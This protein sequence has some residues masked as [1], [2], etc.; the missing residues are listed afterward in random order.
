MLKRSHPSA[1]SV[2]MDAAIQTAWLKAGLKLGLGLLLLGAVVGIRI[3]TVSPE[4]VATD[5][6]TLDP[7]TDR[8][9]VQARTTS[10]AAEPAVPDSDDSLIGDLASGVIEHLPGAGASRRAGDEM[11]SCRSRG[12][13]QFMTADDCATRGGRSTVFESDR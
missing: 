4:R 1:D 6:E 5:V 10:T 9:P 2:S 3:V 11:V 12:A 13:V 7:L 8:A